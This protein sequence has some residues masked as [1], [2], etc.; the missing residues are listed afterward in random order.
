[1]GGQ[2]GGRNDHW[3]LLA[4]RIPRIF[5]Q[6]WVGPDPLPDDH[7]AYAQTWLDHHPG[8]EL[9]LW[10]DENFPA[11][12][13]LIRPEAADLLRAPWER[14]DIFRLELLS[15]QGGVHVD[16]DFECRRSIEPLIEDSD[17][18]VGFRKPGKLNGALMGSVPGHPL[19]EK[20]LREIREQRSYGKSMATGDNLKGTSGPEFIDA[21]FLD[22]P[23]VTL[24]PPECFYPR[25]PEQIDQAYAIHHKARAWKDEAGLR[26]MLEKAEQ[27][28]A[29]QQRETHKWRERAEAAEQK[30]RELGQRV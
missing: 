18:F 14:A 17:V 27:R 28:L 29:K 7:R 11:R 13:T 21:I 20:A 8:W 4:V 9:E 26:A 15:T 19:V 22:Q 6:I 24:I 5:H 12:E 30:L 1:M 25:T 23:G 10:T 3:Y 16:T 2:V